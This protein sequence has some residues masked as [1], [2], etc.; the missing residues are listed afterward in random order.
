[1]K[2]PGALISSFLFFSIVSYGQGHQKERPASRVQ[3][4]ADA[5]AAAKVDKTA[6]AN[7]TAQV[8][9]KLEK[10][11]DVSRARVGDQVLLKTAHAVKQNGHTVIEK[12]SLLLGRITEVQKK[13]KANASSSVS[14]VFDKIISGGKEMPISAMVTSVVSAAASAAAASDGDM[15]STASARSSRSNGSGGLIGG[16]GNAVGGVINTATQTVGS[17]GNTVDTTIGST[18]NGTIGVTGSSSASIA[19]L[20]ISSST[21]ASAAAGSKLSMDGRNLRL[22]KGTVFFLNINSSNELRKN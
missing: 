13:T 6:A 17:V 9:G 3:T 7:T 14:I 10:T 2:I 4:A 1:M 22:D 15:Y 20:S 18:V 5:A 11:L 12:G 8:S 21:D 19:G 16:A